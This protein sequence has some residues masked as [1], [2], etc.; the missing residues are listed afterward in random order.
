M[1]LRQS[2]FQINILNSLWQAQSLDK[3]NLSARESVVLLNAQ[4]Y[5]RGPTSIGNEHGTTRGGFL[6]PTCV[7]IELAT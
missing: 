1:F 5:V 4:Q 7:L 2:S 6:G 3:V